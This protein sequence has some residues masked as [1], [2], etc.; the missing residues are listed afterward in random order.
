[1]LL[2]DIPEGAPST[3]SPIAD[4]IDIDGLKLDIPK[5]FNWISSTAAAEWTTFLSELPSMVQ[6]RTAP[7]SDWMMQ[8][9][10]RMCS[11]QDLSTETPTNTQ[12]TSSEGTVLGDMF[13]LEQASCEV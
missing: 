8:D 11:V 9:V 12:A 7:S 4:R 6:D 10:F 2:Q 13:A 5:F 3:V 1:M